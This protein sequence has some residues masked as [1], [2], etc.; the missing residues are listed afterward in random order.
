MDDPISSLLSRIATFSHYVDA[1]LIAHGM[2]PPRIGSGRSERF[3]VE[4][5][6]RLFRVVLFV[7]LG[8]KG[9]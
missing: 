1:S 5:S 8:K 2:V 4:V 9:L 6:L 3:L 7:W